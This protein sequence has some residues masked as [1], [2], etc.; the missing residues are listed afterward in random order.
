MSNMSY[1]RF[2]NT[3]NDLQDCLYA[4]E[5][6][7]SLEE[8]DLSNGETRAFRVMLDQCREFLELSEK[9]GVPA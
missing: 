8:M 7:D 9:M 6:A 3:S 5:E 2:E 4:M 1:V